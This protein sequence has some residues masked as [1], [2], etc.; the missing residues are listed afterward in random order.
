MAEK[1][2]LLALVIARLSVFGGNGCYSNALEG[3]GPPAQ[4]RCLGASVVV[5]LSNF[6]HRDT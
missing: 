4:P 3:K 1:T 6:Y 2:R 5:F